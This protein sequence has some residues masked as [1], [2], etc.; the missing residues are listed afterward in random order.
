MADACVRCMLAE[1]K[2]TQPFKSCECSIHEHCF[3]EQ[4]KQFQRKPYFKIQCPRHYCRLCRMPCDIQSQVYANCFC[5]RHDSCSR[6]IDTPYCVVH[7]CAV[8]KGHLSTPYNPLSCGCFVCK[9][10]AQNTL[11]PL[12]TQCVGCLFKLNDGEQLLFKQRTL[13]QTV[14]G[15]WGERKALFTKSTILKHNALDLSEMGITVADLIV[16]QLTPDEVFTIK[17]AKDGEMFS[18]LSPTPRNI[19]WLW[20]AIAKHCTDTVKFVADVKVSAFDLVAAGV[21]TRQ[22]HQAGFRAQHFFDG[23]FEPSVFRAAA[24]SLKDW[25]ELFELKKNDLIMKW[26]LTP[27]DYKFLFNKSG[28]DWSSERLKLFLDFTDEDLRMQV[29][30]APARTLVTPTAPASS[31]APQSGGPLKKISYPMSPV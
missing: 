15:M 31:P 11:L 12:G 29:N 6:T 28:T 30:V 4:T 21:T 5:V 16:A 22:L 1:G 26:R 3:E 19:A 9:S 14:A 25:K 27:A 20:E 10:C 23:S 7:D 18:R 8:C 13:I 2:L 24:I 17:F